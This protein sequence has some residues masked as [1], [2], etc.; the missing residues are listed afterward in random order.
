[1]LFTNK[2]I[3]WWWDSEQKL[4]VLNNFLMEAAEELMTN[5][6]SGG[7]RG[8]VVSIQC[9]RFAVYLKWD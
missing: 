5:D 9:K 7:E 2:L 3:L 4:E 6:M 1:M 8:N